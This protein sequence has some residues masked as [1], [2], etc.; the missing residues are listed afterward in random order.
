V[1]NVRIRSFPI[2]M[3]RS[4]AIGWPTRLRRLKKRRAHENSSIDLQRW[5]PGQT[6]AKTRIWTAPALRFETHGSTAANIPT[7]LPR[8]IKLIDA[9]GTLLR[10]MFRSRQDGKVVRQ[11]MGLCSITEG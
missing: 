4:F 1:G 7:R 3:K 2:R 5:T 6:S 9:A 10:F 11:A 8:A